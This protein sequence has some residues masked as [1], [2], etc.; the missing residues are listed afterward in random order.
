MRKILPKEEG[1]I[2]GRI[3]MKKAEEQKKQ[4][5]IA[6]IKE[7]NKPKQ[8]YIDVV[9]TEIVDGSTFYVQVVTQEAEQLEELMKNLAVEDSQEPHK[10]LEGELVK[11]QFTADDAWYRALVLGVDNDQCKVQYVDYGNSEIIPISRI[12]K[13]SNVYHNL[14][15]QAKKAVLAY[16]KTPS[17]DDED[18]LGK[19]SAEFLKDLV[20]GKTMMA[21][22]EKR[23][24]EVLHLSLGDREYKVH[25]N[26]ALLRAGLAK[27]DRIRGE[28]FR[29]ILEKL[30]EEETKARHSHLG[31]WKYG[32]PGSDEE[33]E[34]KKK[35]RG[36]KGR[37]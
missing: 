20:W 3:T 11:A 14:P 5:R 16:I 35:A 2:C 27:V 23:D 36:G 34:D 18:E 8:E 25:V 13:L 12:R 37:N 17:L 29:E 9:V 33:D 26:A 1:K 31:I 7:R 15:S 22:V 4:E 19:E 21:N 32:D 24:G 6:E 10:P 30:R 28:Q